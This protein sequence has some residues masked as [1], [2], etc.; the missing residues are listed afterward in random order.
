MLLNCTGC[1]RKEQQPVETAT[2]DKPTVNNV[3]VDPVKLAEQSIATGELVAAEEQIRSLLI[4]RP[5]D[6]NVKLLSAQLSF[7]KLD[8]VE[9]LGIAKDLSN[10]A[11]HADAA[12]ALVS[13]V[14]VTSPKSVV[15]HENAAWLAAESTLQRDSSN[16]EL[17]SALIDLLNKIGHRHQACRH[18]DWLNKTGKM[19]RRQLFALL[20]RRGSFPFEGL[21]IKDQAPQPEKVSQAI[22]AQARE[23]FDGR[24]LNQAYSLLQP[25][26]SEGWPHP[27][28]AA[29]FAM[30]LAERQ[31]FAE[32]PAWLRSCPNA[33]TG[34]A[35]FWTSIGIWLENE[36]DFQ[37]AAGAFLTAIE[38]D[39]TYYPDYQHLAFCLS[40]LKHDKEWIGRIRERGGSVK[41]STVMAIMSER[42]KNGER[43]LV[44]LTKALQQLG[45]PYE[46]ISWQEFLSRKAGAPQDYLNG[47]IQKRT[48]L[49]QVAEL[50]EMIMQDRRMGLEAKDF[51]RPS[52]D[53]IRS[54]AKL[55]RGSSS[56]P[57]ATP[58]IQS[59]HIAFA[60]VAK[61][62]GIDFQYRNNQDPQVIHLRIH[63]SLGSGIA[64]LDFDLDGLP[65]LYFG[66]GGGDPPTKVAAVSNQ[67]Y[68]NEA[69]K[70]VSV[71]QT[72]SCEDRGYTTGI[73]AGDI[74]QDGFPDLFVGGL[75]VNRLLINQGDGS[76][77]SEK[78]FERAD[79]RFTASV[80]IADVTGDHLPDLIE[81]NYVSDDEIYKPL[82]VPESGIPSGTSPLNYRAA[83]D[84]IWVRDGIKLRRLELETSGQSPAA[85]LGLVVSELDG[86]P[87]NEI[88]IA[89]D[90]YP[91]RFWSL[92]KSGSDINWIEKAAVSG[93][94]VD[95]ARINTA[96]MGVASGDL[97]GNGRMDLHVTNFWEQS[98]TL[99]MH[100][101]PGLFRDLAPRYQLTSVTHPMLAFGTQTMDAN[102]D[103]NLDLLILNGHIEDYSKLGHPFRM[104]PQFLVGTGRG[105]EIALNEAPDSQYFGQKRLGRALATLDFNLDG[106]IDFVAG[107]LSSPIALMKNTSSTSGNWV[108]FQ[109]VGTESE[110][111]AVGCKVSV[112]CQDRTWAAW[113]TA[114]DGYY[115]SNQKTV[116]VSIGELSSIDKVTVDWPTGKSEELAASEANQSY[117]VVEGQGAFQ[118]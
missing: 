62:L 5:D 92:D 28:H 96:G 18:L 113:V 71:T 39:P 93:L 14:L 98:S 37:S 30:V 67:L 2:I 16:H 19:D 54:L 109:L 4:S 70:F 26:M 44:A 51:P 25:L 58:S 53:V 41:K 38:I 82:P 7:A 95:H 8:F 104:K 86:S 64:V 10:S 81:T 22:L 75:G 74:N 88:F 107:H 110:R 12:N 79:H 11:D 59:S 106:R 108:K 13:S 60:D 111:D 29:M 23:H 34:Y 45:R 6:P 57:S 87:G 42:E 3:K 35:G 100:Q 65:D 9:A 63:E 94:A 21:E 78:I 17:R 32:M 118:Y 43:Y 105:F 31:A 36:N 1:N 83:S 90:A 50:R 24:E 101:S 102:L 97:D 99:Y 20:R 49:N 76:F 69:S 61:Q 40:R 52:S 84:R 68:R 91:N 114:G 66:Q 89:C 33:I 117:L 73:A 27:E 15:D 80:G 116:H 77:R 115:S 48:Q 46:M 85:S 72:A 56:V 103:G 47:L 55:D 112:T